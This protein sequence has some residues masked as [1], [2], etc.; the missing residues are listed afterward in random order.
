[1]TVLGRTIVKHYFGRDIN[2]VLGGTLLKIV[3]REI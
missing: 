3:L 1:M 2:T